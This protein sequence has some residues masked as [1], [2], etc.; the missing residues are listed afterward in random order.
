M[1]ENAP[2]FSMDTASHAIFHLTL[3]LLLKPARNTGLEKTTRRF[4]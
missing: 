3:R 2:H 4:K 1:P